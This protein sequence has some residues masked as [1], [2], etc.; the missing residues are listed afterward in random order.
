MKPFKKLKKIPFFPLLSDRHT[1]IGG[2]PVVDELCQQ[3]T[4][5]AVYVVARLF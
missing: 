4:F 1:R 3:H 2:R 5:V